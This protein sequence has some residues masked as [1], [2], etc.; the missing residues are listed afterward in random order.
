MN[1]QIKW[2]GKYYL[3][4]NIPVSEFLDKYR[5]FNVVV[6]RTGSMVPARATEYFEERNMQHLTPHKKYE[7]RRRKK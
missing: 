4:T 3:Q 6:P 7:Q 1:T 5:Y 2:R